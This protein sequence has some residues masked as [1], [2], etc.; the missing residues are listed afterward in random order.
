[1]F[2]R[3]TVYSEDAA[4]TSSQHVEF[5]LFSAQPPTG[6]ERE[7]GRERGSRVWRRGNDEVR[8]DEVEAVNSTSLPP[9]FFLQPHRQGRIRLGEEENKGDQKEVEWKKEE[10]REGRNGEDTKKLLRASTEYL[11]KKNVQREERRAEGS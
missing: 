9:L 11:V 5:P 7:G 6:R 10:R 2:G 1:M 8:G 3:E 4:G